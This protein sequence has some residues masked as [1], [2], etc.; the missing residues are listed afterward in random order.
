[1]LSY[2]DN[3]KQN[4]GINHNNLEVGLVKTF[5][6]NGQRNISGA[7]E[8]IRQERMRRRYTPSDLAARVQ[9]NSVILERDCIR[10]IENGPRMVQDFE[11][12]GRWPVRW[13]LQPTGCRKWKKNNFAACFMFAAILFSG[14]RPIDFSNYYRLLNQ[15]G[16][17][18]HKSQRL[19]TLYME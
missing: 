14:G 6:Y 18:F 3:V 17:C 5:N 7:G 19:N 12:G 15:K 11:L 2:C 9:V 10:R 13:A 16:G 1:M 8:R 4:F